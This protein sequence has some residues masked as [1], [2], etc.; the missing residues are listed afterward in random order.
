MSAPNHA[1]PAINMSP[2]KVLSIAPIVSFLLFIALFAGF[3]G[4]RYMMAN[5]LQEVGT[6][7]AL[8]VFVLGAWLALF[9][10]TQSEWKAWVYTPCW[11]VAGVMVVSSVMFGINFGES[12]L[13]SLF[14]AREFLLAFIGP[15]IVLIVKSG[16]PLASLRTVLFATLL[17]LM[18]NYLFFY[19]TL[20]LRAA[21][22]SSDHTISNLVTYDEWRGFRLKPS[23]VTVMLALLTGVM[24]VLQRASVGSVL[25][26]FV[27]VCLAAH[28]W[29]IVMFRSTLATMLL[30]IGIYAL[31]LSKPNRLAL[32]LLTVPVAIIALPMVVQIVGEHFLGADGGSLRLKSYVLAI[33]TIPEYFFLGVGED[34]SYGRTYQQLF[35]RTFYP[36]DIGIIGVMFKYGLVGLLVYVYVHFLI[37]FRLW[38]ANIGVRFREGKTD[39]ILWALLILM[40]A[41]TLNLPLIAGLGYAQGVTTGSLA[42][43]YAYLRH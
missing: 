4:G 13:F 2:T 3:Q 17:A 27:L 26:G 37:V 40:V 12:V 25:F 30:G 32:L 31:F 23:M 24:L 18:V 21:F 41:Q 7:C 14:S 11:L 1:N 10:I 29:S 28:I 39:P 33:N 9:R 5:R 38:K 6:L 36:S 42:L 35:S 8:L 22:F 19:H 43:A 16:Y 15:A 20:D 34:N